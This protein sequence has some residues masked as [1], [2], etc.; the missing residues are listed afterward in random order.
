MTL[1][2]VVL[3]TPVKGTTDNV[4]LTASI[5][6]KGDFALVDFKSTFAFFL[7][8]N[9]NERLNLSIYSRLIDDE[10]NVDGDIK[11]NRLFYSINALSLLFELCYPLIQE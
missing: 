7:V 3:A 1:R 8:E 4:S 6:Q 10:D 5:K 2:C 11:E 9:L